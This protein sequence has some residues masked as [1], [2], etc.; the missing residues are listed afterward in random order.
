MRFLIPLL[1]LLLAPVALAHEPTATSL[2]DGPYLRR[3]GKGL[4]AEWVCEGQVQRAR[5]AFHHGRATVPAR[6]GYPHALEIAAKPAEPPVRAER[7]MPARLAALSD[8]H[9]QYGL[10]RQLLRAQGLIDAQDRWAWGDGLLVVGGDVFDRGPQ[11]TE[12]FWL[13]QQLQGQARAAGGD[14]LFVLGNHETMTLYDDLRY[15]NPK[16]AQ[17]ATLLGR[18]YPALYDGDSVLGAWLRQAPAMARV[19]DT[20][21]LHGGISPEFLAQ[22]ID[23]DEANTRYRQSLGTPKAQVKA[24]PR[25]APLY[26]GKTSPI[27]Y[28]GYF[29][30]RAT[31]ETVTA[32]LRELGVS[33][34]VVGHT[35]MAHVGSYFDGRVI[36]IDSSIKRG[37]SGEMLLIE[38]GQVSRGL[39]DGS[40]AVMLPGDGEDEDD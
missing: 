22:G 7:P 14:V 29:D 23:R 25:T 12:S 18:P 35:S 5:I 26:D 11:V 19:G 9:G 21:F 16:Y 17:V 10:L 40:R 31:P 30:G 3:D 13:L 32:V 8:I 28:R 20:L 38:D 39:L 1:A 15:L 34:I 2:D 37:V 6:C 4:A 33:R 27:W 24:D 36:A